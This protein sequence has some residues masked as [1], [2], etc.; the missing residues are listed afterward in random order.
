MECWCRWF[1][2]GLAPSRS[3]EH[4]VVSIIRVSKDIKGFCE[5][6]CKNDY[7]Y[8]TW[9][10]SEGLSGQSTTRHQVAQLWAPGKYFDH[11]TKFDADLVTIVASLF[12]EGQEGE[13]EEKAHPSP[14]PFADD[15]WLTIFSTQIIFPP[16]DNRDVLLSLKENTLEQNEKS[17]ISFQANTLIW[18]INHNKLWKTWIYF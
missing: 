6:N 16:R 3:P 11:W 10:S 8:M 4:W 17:S 2:Q 12:G 13:N 1:A 14:F 5:C 7:D 15:F 18:L 9:K